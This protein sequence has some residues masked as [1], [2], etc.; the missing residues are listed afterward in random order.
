MKDYFSGDEESY[1]SNYYYLDFDFF[2]F[3]FFFFLLAVG[4]KT[5]SWSVFL[6]AEPCSSS[7]PLSECISSSVSPLFSCFSPLHFFN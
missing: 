7:S 1:V 3:Y 6:E 2:E 5:T 4:V